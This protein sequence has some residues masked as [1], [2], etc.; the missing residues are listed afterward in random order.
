MRYTGL[1]DNGGTYAA[2]RVP[3]PEAPYP[4]DYIIDK[5]G[6]I[7]FFETEYDPQECIKVIKQSLRYRPPV[8]VAVVPDA[9]QVQPGGTLGYTL[10]LKNNT[11]QA[12]NFEVTAEEIQPSSARQTLWGPQNYQLNAGD[13][14]VVHLDEPIPAGTPLGSYSL[15]I[16]VGATQEVWSVDGFNFTVY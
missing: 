8:T 14:L 16:K 11:Q 1:I 2:Y 4:Q 5:Q 10:T 3:D 13:T 7:R 6:K 15:K 9:T 12:T